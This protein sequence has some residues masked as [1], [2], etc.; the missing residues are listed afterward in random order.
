MVEIWLVFFFNKID[1]GKEDFHTKQK[2]TS[3]LPQSKKIKKVPVPDTI[4]RRRTRS[5]KN[6][7]DENK[8]LE[9]TMENSP[10]HQ[11]EA[12]STDNS[13]KTLMQNSFDNR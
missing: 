13:K 12:N 9:K 4:E 7:E 5:M 1:G 6:K 11:L 8:S 2:E 3:L 10:N